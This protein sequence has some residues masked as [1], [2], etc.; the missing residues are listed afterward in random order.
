[1]STFIRIST[2]KCSLGG[3]KYF[4]PF[5]DWTTKYTKVY[6]IPNKEAETVLGKLRLGPNCTLAIRSNSF[7]RATIVALG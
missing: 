4:V 3:C 6:V 2:E 7:F 5:K 1:M